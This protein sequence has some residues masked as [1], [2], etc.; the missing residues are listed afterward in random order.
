[1]NTQ[2]QNKAFPLAVR[3]LGGNSCPS[4]RAGDVPEVTLGKWSSVTLSYGLGL[5]S[6]W[7]GQTRKGNRGL[8]IA[9]EFVYRPVV[10]CYSGG[11]W[12]TWIT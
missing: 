8:L 10:P 3:P 1:M 9:Q 2:A 7:M 5:I 11:G 6:T 12:G 4:T